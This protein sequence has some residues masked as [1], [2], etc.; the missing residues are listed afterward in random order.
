MIIARGGVGC[1]VTSSS[2]VTRVICADIAVV[3]IGGC[4]SYTCASTAMVIGS[5]GV[6]VVA[7]SAVGCVGIGALSVTWIAGTSSVALIQCGAS[8][9]V[10]S[11]ATTSL[12]SISL[13]TRVAIVAR[14]AVRCV[15]IGANSTS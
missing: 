10:R 6:A 12:A 11:C 13:S 1:V 2:R 7:S 15:G 9:E 8:D 14:S 3:A 4:S 5:A